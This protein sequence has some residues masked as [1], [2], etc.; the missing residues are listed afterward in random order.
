MIRVTLAVESRGNKLFATM[1]FT[2]EGQYP[3]DLVKFIT[4]P[5]GKPDNDYFLIIDHHER[6]LDYK[7]MMKKR[8]PPDEDGFFWLAPGQSVQSGEVCLNDYYPIPKKGGLQLSYSSYNHF[9]GFSAE[10]VSNPVTIV[11]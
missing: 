2:N 9:A 3:L 11:L 7:G 8:A 10:L 6:E 5:T 4:I 1:T